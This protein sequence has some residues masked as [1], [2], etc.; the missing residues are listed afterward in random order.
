MVQRATFSGSTIVGNKPALNAADA[1]LIGALKSEIKVEQE[2]ELEEPSLVKKFLE[3]TGYSIVETEGQDE[4]KLHRKEGGETVNIY[5]S[6]SDIT[7]SESFVEEEGAE[8][9]GEQESDFDE[10]L[11]SPIRLNIVV[12]KPAGA[13][14][15]EAIAEQDVILVESIIPYKDGKLATD[16]TPDAD[17]KRRM[18]Y[19][20]PPFNVLD[21]SVQGAVE[22]FLEARNINAEMAQ[23][24]TEYA[25]FRETKEYIQWLKDIQAIVEAN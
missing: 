21:E 15:I 23:V 11:N 13:L 24:I 6:V 14:G 17:Y 20:G 1:E 2:S 9:D 4:V 19:Q 3:S 22:Q 7:N 10:E 16:D 8:N 12:E 18:L 25:A 5:F